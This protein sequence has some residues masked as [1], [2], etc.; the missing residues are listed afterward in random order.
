MKED[1]LT[2]QWPETGELTVVIR[3]NETATVK[4][5]PSQAA[6]ENGLRKASQNAAYDNERDEHPH[7]HGK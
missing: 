6:I 4:F 2:F 5:K 1:K 3:G 7:T